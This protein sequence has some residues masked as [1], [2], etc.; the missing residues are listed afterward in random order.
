MKKIYLLAVLATVL[1]SLVSCEDFNE[2]NFPGYDQAAVPKNLVSYTY[3]LVDADYSTIS[4]AALALAKTKADSVKAT[5]IGKNKFFV[6]TIPANKYL[7]LLLNTKYLYAD[8]NSTAMVTYNYNIPYDT[9][10]ID[11]ANKY[12]LADED[13]VAMGTASN[14][15][16]KFKNFSSSID[17]NFYI[18]IWLKTKFLYAKSGEVKMVRYKYYVSSSVTNIIPEVYIFDGTVWAKYK[19]LTQKTD[20]CLYSGKFWV[21]DPT[22][23]ITQTSNDRSVDTNG[24]PANMQNM[25]SVIVHAVKADPNIAKY[26][27]SYKNDEYYYG[28]SAYQGNFSFEYTKREASPYSDEALKALSSE[29]DKI[30]LMFTRVNEAI[31]IYLKYAYPTLKAKTDDG[32]DQYL[33]I[34][35]KVY[36]KY[37]SG[38]TTNTYQA[39]FQCTDIG[40]FK[41]IERKKL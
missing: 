10:K 21:F 8:A 37:P 27:S 1:C 12:I 32:F 22:I 26:I 13:Y 2:K 33:S 3:T 25:F 29:T 16:G 15:P 20:Q 28:A 11:A 23:Y 30:N 31:I 36:E 19:S 7:P 6:D 18:P 17:P 41:F 39:K 9:T 24:Y 5:A 34:T 38:T 35:F 40:S 4:K 14:Q